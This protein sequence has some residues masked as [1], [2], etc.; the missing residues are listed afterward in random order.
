MGGRM[1]VR[2][3]DKLDCVP[4]RSRIYLCEGFVAYIK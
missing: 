4:G 2:S 1:D 3:G